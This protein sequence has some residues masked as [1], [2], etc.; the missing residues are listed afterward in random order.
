MTTE[1]E[2]IDGFKSI[3]QYRKDMEAS[4][5]VREYIRS[6]ENTPN[7]N[8]TRLTPEYSTTGNN[9]EKIIE[10]RKQLYRT[11]WEKFPNRPEF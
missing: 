7:L 4:G 6:D 11:L 1:L 10:S 8:I 9:V 3:I 5:I 2:S